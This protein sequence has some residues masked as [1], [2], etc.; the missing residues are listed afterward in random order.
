MSRL[1]PDLWDKI[2]VFEIRYYSPADDRFNTLCRACPGVGNVNLVNRPFAGLA[3][4][5]GMKPDA[6]KVPPD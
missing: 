3:L 5:M 1:N 2:Q 6:V 4:A